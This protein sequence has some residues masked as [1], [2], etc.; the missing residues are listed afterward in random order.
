LA[1]EFGDNLG[2]LMLGNIARAFDDPLN[3]LNELESYK[4][5]GEIRQ[6]S[7]KK[8]RKKITTFEI[9]LPR[10]QACIL[11]GVPKLLKDRDIESP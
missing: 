1:K 10:V 2:T 11:V 3:L 8:E 5:P 7:L 6:Q 4:K 9:G